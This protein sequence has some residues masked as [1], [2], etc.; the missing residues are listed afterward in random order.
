MGDLPDD[1]E[2]LEEMLQRL[3]DAEAPWP[4]LRVPFG[5]GHTAIAVY[6][7]YEDENNVEFAVRHPAWGR[8]G[9]LGNFG[10]E[11]AGPGLSWAELTTIAANVPE[12]ASAADG[13]IDPAQRLLLLLPMLGDV[14]TPTDAWSVVAEAMS[15]CGIPEDAAVRLAKELVGTSTEDHQ[16]KPS[17]TVGEDSPVPVCSSNYSPRRIPLALGITPDQAQALAAALTETRPRQP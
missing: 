9:H 2:A 4:V 10:P 16:I 14:A 8:L 7:N 6:A 1:E 15:R 11:G 3:S 17:W 13:L 5:G 12:N